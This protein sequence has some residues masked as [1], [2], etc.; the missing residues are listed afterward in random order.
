MRTL[1]LDIGEKRIGVAV[2]DPIGKVATPLTVLD[3]PALAGDPSPLLRLIADYEVDLVVVGLPISL[4]GAEGPQA[5]RVRATA[6][7]LSERIGVRLTYHDER[8]STAEARRVMTTSG[9]SQREQRGTVD[10]V[11]AALFLQSYLDSTTV[12]AEGVDSADA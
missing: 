3:A 11:A 5:E 10:K 9:V 1:G 7:R 12:D 6:E 2:S 8:L 4:D